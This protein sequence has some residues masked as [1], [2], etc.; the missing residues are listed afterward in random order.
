MLTPCINI[1]KLDPNSLK[2]I[3]CKRTAEQIQNWSKL[4]DQERQEII[5][6]LKGR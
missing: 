4:T 1:C 5:T 3:G 2:C 6:R